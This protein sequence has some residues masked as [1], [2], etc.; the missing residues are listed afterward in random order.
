MQRLGVA[1]ELSPAGGMAVRRA[2]A[3][4]GVLAET[5]GLRITAQPTDGGCTYRFS[6]EQESRDTDYII[7][8]HGVKLMVDPFSAEHID[9]SAIDFE[10][11]DQGATFTVTPPEWF[12]KR[13]APLVA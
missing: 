6:I 10:Q 13:K 11:T 4:A 7:A 8:R 2:M 3:A 1:L 5:G 9:G 12:R